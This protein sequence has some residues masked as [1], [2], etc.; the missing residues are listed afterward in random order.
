MFV[1]NRQ[2]IRRGCGFTLFMFILTAALFS[3]IAGTRS[4]S[5]GEGLLE[6]VP[7]VYGDDRLVVINGTEDTAYQY[8]FSGSAEQ[9]WIDYRVP[10]QLSALPGEERQFQLQVRDKMG[11]NA[12]GPQTF[13]YVI[14]KL[15]PGPPQILFD[16]G[17]NGTSMQ[18]SPNAENDTVQYWIDSFQRNEFRRWT[19]GN[20]P[21]DEGALVKAYSVDRAG[22]HSEVVTRQATAALRCAELES[23][24]LRSPAAG[25]FQNTQMLVIANPECFEWIRYS[26]D[27]SNP[28]ASGIRY[29]G[30]VRLDVR[31]DIRLRI[32]A[33]I[34]LSEEVL[35]AETNYTVVQESPLQIDVSSGASLYDLDRLPVP[36]VS[37]DFI[38]HY[39]LKEKQVSRRD[40]Q[41]TEP[42]RFSLT[43]GMINYIPYRIGVYNSD[44]GKM[45][46]YR[47]FYVVDR[48][49][50]GPPL[51]ETSGNPP[52]QTQETVRIRA[53]S[54][55]AVYY[56]TDGSTP[57]RFAGRY[58]NPFT[59]RPEGTSNIGTV[60]VQAV[61][62][63]PNGNTSEVSRLLVPFDREAPVPPTYTV[64]SRT[65]NETVFA[66][67]HPEKDIEFVYNIGYDRTSTLQLE[68]G[69][70]C[71][72]RLVRVAFPYGYTG[73]AMIRFGARDEAG[74]LSQPTA[75][76]EVSVDTVPPPPPEITVR[77]LRV[78]M[79]GA[80]K[81]SYR[82]EPGDP[83]FQEYT[84]PVRLQTAADEKV[85]YQ[86]YG[87][88]ED[89]AGNI[90]PTAKVQVVYDR[91]PAELPE[92]SGIR[93]GAHYREPI[94][95]EIIEAYPD[96]VT[97]YTLTAEELKHRDGAEA[98][99][100]EAPGDMP[101]P[102]LGDRMLQG[103]LTLRGEEK[104]EIVYTLR[105]RSYIPGSESWSETA[106]YQVVID[107]LAPAPKD[108]QQLIQPGLFNETF[109]L[110]EKNIPRN[111]NLWLYVSESQL[112]TEEFTAENIRV[113]RL[114]AR[115]GVNIEGKPGEEITYY[116][117]TAA[118]DLAGNSSV[119]GPFS[120]VIDRSRP[121][122]PALTGV[123]TGRFT[124]SSVTLQP[125]EGYEHTIRYELTDD[126]SIPQVPGDD[127]QIMSGPITLL[128][129][130]GNE[131]SYY[132]LYRAVD[133]AGN[134]SNTATVHV[135]ILRT[136]PLEPV[137]NILRVGQ[138]LWEISFNAGEGKNIFYSIGGGEFTEYR[139]PVLY[140]MPSDI[141]MRSIEAYSI[142][143][144]GGRSKVISRRLD[145]EEGDAAP[146][147]GV[148]DGK[149]Y[150]RDIS[151]S[152][153]LEDIDLRY[154]LT[155]GRGAMPVLTGSSPR[156][157]GPLKIPADPEREIR[158]RLKVGIYE[159]DTGT[160]Y[161]TRSYDFTVD[162][163]PPLAPELA[164]IEEGVH[165]T[166]DQ[167]L[168][169]DSEE[170]GTVVY[171]SIRE[172]EGPET[173]S[174]RYTKPEKVQ[175]RGG[176][177]KDFTVEMWAIDQAGNRSRTRRVS[178][179]ID[180]AGIYVSPNGRDGNNGGKDA[181]FR[182]MDRALYEAANSNRNTIYLSKGEY[183][184]SKPIIIDTQ[185]NIRG[186]YDDSD[187][188]RRS[189]NKTLISA[190]AS[191]TAERSVFELRDGTLR[192][193]DIVLSNH[194]MSG[195]IILQQGDFSTLIVRQS[196]LLHASGRARVFIR[197]NGGNLLFTDTRIEAGGAASGRIMQLT[198]ASLAFKDSI[199]EVADVSGV[200]T[201][202][203]LEA[204][205]AEFTS[206]GVAV[207]SAGTSI[208]VHSRESEVS[209]IDS[210]IE[211]GAGTAQSTAVRQKGGT[212]EI[213]GSTIGRMD[214]ET[215]TIARMATGVEADNARINIEGSLL[216][217]SGRTAVV[218]MNIRSSSVTVNDSRLEN[219]P[220]DEFS[221]LVRVNGGSCTLSNVEMRSRESYELYGIKA[222]GRAAV[223]VRSSSIDLAPAQ[224][225]CTGIMLDARTI[226]TIQ[227]S[228]L[229]ASGSRGAA[230]VRQEGSGFQQ[231]NGT[232]S[233]NL[234][235]IENTFSG[236]D[237]LLINAREQ[238]RTIEALE[239]EKPPF[240]M[241]TPHRGNSQE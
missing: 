239:S 206:A 225:I 109:F 44:D 184:L 142:D 52:F 165:Y 57:D 233:P 3:Q 119:S 64:V 103:S 159:P 49:I 48:R 147:Q 218:Q 138:R 113:N 63:F 143:E 162:S 74:N 12:G 98:L 135:T 90:S 186:G 37:E 72:G 204:C 46:Q 88:A 87:T 42:V 14:D 212:L 172:S 2:T 156:L 201:V 155:V 84:E 77:D 160:F 208:T 157:T 232:P 235:L 132:L 133:A 167:T 200:L 188:T 29:D 22:N 78:N 91:R 1:F 81:L 231:G 111:E 35:T 106:E 8:R 5:P 192:L 149:L 216:N 65:Q 199:V 23:L 102:D 99:P 148:E 223:L 207:G 95:I 139:Y 215:G 11:R 101:P 55:A 196:L 221:Y 241:K 67:D 129:D 41:L 182:T 83:E 126:D 6:P 21:L 96:S 36:D 134:Y 75:L 161:S 178:F 127:S 170:D 60:D 4:A 9:T 15:P 163:A 209:I 174:R 115:A 92:I 124:R 195:P 61:A 211:N 228:R 123:P 122:V 190:A 213:R 181:P 141:K 176:V 173:P 107:R 116:I 197:T 18:F 153:R 28:E 234:K 237:Y 68:A 130:G 187:W 217:A 214:G 108:M 131:K 240:D 56:T 89:T 224:N 30:P 203:D 151:I 152:P 145:R 25:S 136:E 47:S 19:G 20:I 86:I 146:V 164:G 39:S 238:V 34:L 51:I 137:V 179:V 104:R 79:T 150:N 189:G 120:I 33:G 112:P 194:R 17:R 97:Y 69:S 82:I 175:V 80:G 193:D 32:A 144:S 171:Y 185:L 114:S 158:Y 180:K 26:I 24:D 70:A 45:Y 94:T 125:P 38:I 210:Y 128:G 168:R 236:W 27:G 230:A 62:R 40:R 198:E 121:E 177:R 85:S 59:I 54:E 220:A 76:E 43:E 71:C 183:T 100:P 202:F 13:Q 117:Y 110:R 10:L 222:E 66:L 226:G 93:D 154:E 219:G 140:E 73:S 191:F 58:R 50:P 229:S 166:E 7:G 118:F 53:A 31:G 105:I 169:I 227:S 16:G 205:E